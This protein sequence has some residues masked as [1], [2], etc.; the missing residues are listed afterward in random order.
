MSSHF[1]VG[2]LVGV[3]GVYAWRKFQAS[4]KTA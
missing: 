2:V 3:A 1:V 4:K